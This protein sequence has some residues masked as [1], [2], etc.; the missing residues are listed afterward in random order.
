MNGCLAHMHACVFVRWHASCA[1]VA[2]CAARLPVLTK[3]SALPQRRCGYCLQQHGMQQK[4]LDKDPSCVSWSGSCHI[5]SV[6]CMQVSLPPPSNVWVME[7][8]VRVRGVSLPSHCTR[9]MRAVGTLWSGHTKGY[10]N[11][12]ICPVQKNAR[13]IVACWRR[14]KRPRRRPAHLSPRRHAQVTGQHLVEACWS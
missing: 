12:H 3:P 10:S 1:C 13:C 14:M 8:A 5:V 7:Q 4:A 11:Q 2:H 6:A 9:A